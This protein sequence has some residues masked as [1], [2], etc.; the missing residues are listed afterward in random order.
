[1]FS[2]T[3]R[4]LQTEH[5]LLITGTPLQNNLHELWALLNFLLPDVFES[6]EQFDELFNLDVDDDSKKKVSL[7]ITRSRLI[8]F[9]SQILDS[10]I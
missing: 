4:A 7:F 5:R 9:R 8:T 6:S 3:I 10:L 2:Q 1:M